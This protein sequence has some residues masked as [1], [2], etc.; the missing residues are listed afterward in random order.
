MF[1]IWSFIV[2]AL[3]SLMLLLW[4]KHAYRSI[5]PARRKDDVNDNR[6][7]DF[8]RETKRLFEAHVSGPSLLSISGKL[9]EQFKPKLQSSDICM[10]PSY[11]H[12]L[13][14][15][16]ERGTYLALDVGGS[17]LRVAAVR[18]FGRRN[19]HE[20]SMEILK[21]KAFRIDSLVKALKG[22]AFFDWMAEK[23]AEVL[24]EPVV[25]EAHGSGRVA[26]GLA[27]SF[28]IQYVEVS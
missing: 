14:S 13:P 16:K 28:A 3:D 1:D 27:W 19:G 22:H 18:L 15:G 4:P 23:I 11:I 20:K 12:T 6:M 2:D 26:M 8:L 24:E 5:H 17:T 25:K 9:Q 7:E 10:L 21:M